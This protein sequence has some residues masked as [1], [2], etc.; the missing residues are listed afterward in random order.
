MFFKIS[1]RF[2][3]NRPGDVSLITILY[4]TRCISELNIPD[5]DAA[6]GNWSGQSV[7]SFVFPLSVLE[8]EDLASGVLISCLLSV[9]NALLLNFPVFLCFLQPGGLDFDSWVFLRFF[10][11][12]AASFESSVV[13]WHCCDG[14]DVLNEAAVANLSET[15]RN[16]KE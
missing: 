3:K 11:C 12:D 8:S 1:T 5:S 7:F 16:C 2:R 9:L 15:V 10:E 14:F 13:L 4:T 6:L